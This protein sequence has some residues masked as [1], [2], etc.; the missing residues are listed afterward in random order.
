MPPTLALYICTIFI[1]CLFIMDYRRKHY[2]SFGLWIPLIWVMIIGS[3]LL[4]QWQVK[5]SVLSPV[6]G[7]LQGS[8]LDRTVFSIL[9]VIG[10]VVLLKRKI[11]WSWVLKRNIWIFMLLGYCGI[12]IMWSDYPFVSFKRWIKEVGNFI[13]VM[14]VLTD[15]DSIE[16]LKTLIRRCSFV[17]IP[18]SIVL[19]KYYPYLGRAFSPWGGSEYVGV[20]TSKNMLATLCLVC[21]LFFIW[22][23]YAQWHNK[24]VVEEKNEKYINI[25]F[26]LMISW[27][28]I[29][30]NSANT[31]GTLFIGICILLIL[32]L[33]RKNLQFLGIYIFF[34]F[35]F[36]VFFQIT[37]DI[38]GLTVT[39]LGRDMTF[40]GRT[41]LWKTV[42]NMD[43][44][45]LI[46]TGYESFW[47]GDR[48]RTLWEKHWWRPNQAHNGFIEIYLNMGMV[49]VFLLTSVIMSAYRKI[50]K[51]LLNEFYYGSLRLVFLVVA[52]IYSVM[53]AGFKGMSLMWFIFLLITIEVPRTAPSAAQKNNV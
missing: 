8:F 44:N 45:P 20:A 21:G 1:I 12:S 33:I 16:A 10:F 23:L 26:L 3:R 28:L 42:M 5:K 50:R 25:F 43:T 19:I 27:L 35:V 9:I 6:E 39:T 29:K 31:F 18:F 2:S 32:N 47:L 14:I 13:M 41:E 52:L 11:N 15:K 53:E 40:T 49:G 37:F 4:S 38:I 22:L 48:L 34:A 17:L 24:N 51:T 7:V 46:G 36:F 30:A